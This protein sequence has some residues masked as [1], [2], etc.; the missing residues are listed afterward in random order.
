[1]KDNFEIPAFLRRTDKTKPRVIKA[2]RVTRIKAPAGKSQWNLPKTMDDVARQILR[3]QNAE[4]ER[5]K[6]ARLAALKV[7]K[8]K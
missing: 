3:E 7:S 4:H 6:K 1:M 2:A 8:G 5:R